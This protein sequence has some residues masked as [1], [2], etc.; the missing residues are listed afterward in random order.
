[1][2]GAAL[3]VLSEG[4]CVASVFPVL[5]YY[6]QDL[7][8]GPAEIGILFALMAAPKI[9]MNPLFGRLSDLWGRRPAL[10]AASCGTLAG[11]ITWALA[12]SIHW[13]MV[14]RLIAGMFG[15]QAALAQAVAADVSR[16][17]DRAAS[18]GKL[19]AAFAIALTFGP[20]LGGLVADRLSYAAVGW[21]NAI[22]QLTALAV[23]LFVLPETRY[24]AVP[25]A[26]DPQPNLPEVEAPLRSGPQK[27]A[28]A[29]RDAIVL[30]LLAVTFFMTLGFAEINSTYALVAQHRYGYTPTQTGYVFATLG[31]IA[32][33]VQ[34]GAVRR[35]VANF[36]ER[37]L[38]LAG[39]VLLAAG[40]GVTGLNISLRVFWG[41]TIFIAVG[42][43]LS[44]PCLTGRL[45]RQ[46]PAKEQGSILGL[47]Q[48][49][50]GVGRAGGAGLGGWLYGWLGA[51][52]TYSLAA[53]LI[54]FAAC[55]LALPR[56]R[57]STPPAGEPTPS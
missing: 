54:V 55:L 35:L 6:C 14:S 37:P 52:A 10:F 39:M 3:V 15:A 36:G 47:N 32:A 7:G 56:P 25:T 13:L 22:F 57:R 48:G 38:A 4:L 50:T 51:R 43:A 33:L 44:I 40:M 18:V 26:T 9:V 5:S 27:S 8:G 31:I 28:V 17:E 41:A 45:S 11:S 21:M 34:G 53:G 1:M 16:P 24:A 42:S 2:F 23:V 29:W 19:G 49:I 30:Q 20:A 46:V 12:P